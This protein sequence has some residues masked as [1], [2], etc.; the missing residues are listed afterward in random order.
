PPPAAAA[1]PADGRGSQHRRPVATAGLVCGQR[2]SQR[3]AEDRNTGGPARTTPPRRQPASQPPARERHAPGGWAAGAPPGRR[4]S[5]RT[6]EE[7][8]AGGG[9]VAVEPFGQRP[10]QRTAEDRNEEEARQGAAI[11][12]AAA[13]PADGR[14][15]QHIR[16]TDR[17]LDLRA[18]AVP[19]D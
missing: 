7:R 15:S 5:H 6:A 12:R 18:A 13:V 4:R 2:P 14:G 16:L 3:T 9:V 8:N 11:V 10:S 1:V 19:A 17:L